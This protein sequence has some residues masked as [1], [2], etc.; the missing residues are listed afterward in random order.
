MDGLLFFLAL[1]TSIIFVAIPVLLTA[2]IIH[3]YRQLERMTGA[4]TATLR[5]LIAYL[6]RGQRP[7]PGVNGVRPPPPKQDWWEALLGYFRPATV[8]PS[9]VE[10][11][12]ILDDFEDY[13]AVLRGGN[14]EGERYMRFKR[15]SLKMRQDVERDVEYCRTYTET[16]PY[17][18]I[19]GTVLG[20][21]FSPAVF[22]GVAGAASPPTITIGGLVLA[23]SS[24]AAA[25]ACI[26]VIKLFYE[27]AIIP[28]Y[29]AFE[30]ALLAL[31]D[32]AGRFGGI[33][34][35]RVYEAPVQ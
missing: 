11:Y 22:G 5:A 32:Y 27:N 7:E 1:L 17:L 19:L 20:F 33:A 25:L 6:E 24:T 10:E 2:S 15:K 35:E 14:T 21:F 31:D 30:Q 28:K 23:L 16:L 12:N 13:L 18:G 34:R 9:P 26:I 8:A 4:Y 29:L 3:R